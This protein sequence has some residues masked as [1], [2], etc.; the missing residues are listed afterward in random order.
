M[1]LGDV[2]AFVAVV[3]ASS[4][5]AAAAR[6]RAP[7]SA[8]SRRVARLEE[9]LGARL[10][11]RT[12]RSLALTEAGASYH[13]SATQALGQLREAAAVVSERSEEPSGT[14]RI[15][16]PVDT[17]A[18]TAID[19]LTQFVREYPKVNVEV[20]LSARIVDLVAEGYDLALRAGPLRDSSLVARKLGDT[21]AILAASPEYVARRGMPQRPADLINHDCVLFRATRGESRW[22]LHG[23]DG[24][25]EEV[26]VQGRLSGSDFSFIRA[27]ALHGAGIALLP[28]PAALLDMNCGRLVRVLPD[29]SGFS[30]P[31]HL[32]YPSAR[33][34]PLRVAVLRDFIL[35]NLKINELPPCKKSHGAHEHEVEHKRG[36]G[37]GS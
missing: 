32:V 1:D 37:T 19:V 30:S 9:A 18:V 33:F 11:Q 10:L 35:K 31:F 36:R 7:K 6:L 13:A 25:E 12:T 26:N 15:T 16:M 17:G 3:D 29:Y 20:D 4:F 5:T 27:A 21:V 34:M 23:P 28:S 2:E 24:R 8:L 22:R 14:V